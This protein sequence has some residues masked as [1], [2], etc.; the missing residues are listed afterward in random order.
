MPLLSSP[1]SQFTNFYGQVGK[2]FFVKSNLHF[3]KSTTVEMFPVFCIPQRYTFWKFLFPF[4]PSLSFIL[5]HKRKYSWIFCAQ[6]QRHWRKPWEIQKCKT[7]KRDGEWETCFK[8][9]KKWGKV[10][11]YTFRKFRQ[12]RVRMLEDL[13]LWIP[14]CRRQRIMSF[15][16]ESEG[17]QSKEKQHT[18]SAIHCSHSQPSW[19][20]ANCHH[21]K[22]M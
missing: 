17:I 14:D 11:I 4:H 7:G 10:Q 8:I 18:F 16:Q 6:I 22:I 3:P 19:H 5:R 15:C 2:F 1:A 21:G 12:W 9:C 13:L 20:N